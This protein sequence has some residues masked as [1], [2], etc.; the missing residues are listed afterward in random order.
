MITGEDIDRLY[1]EQE[2]SNI[3][4]D[5]N[6]R[7]TRRSV[8]M[9]QVNDPTR[10]GIPALT[11]LLIR[12]CGNN[13]DTFEEAIRLVQLFMDQAEKDALKTVQKMVKET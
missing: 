2:A 6:A 1:A 13:Y 9:M 5:D 4:P 12:V 11:T 7:D 3:H 8:Q 10:I